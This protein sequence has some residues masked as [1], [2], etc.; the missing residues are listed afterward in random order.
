MHIITGNNSSIVSTEKEF[1]IV[2]GEHISKPLPLDPEII[3]LL[4]DLLSTDET[5]P[6]V[7]ARWA[8][9][10]QEKRERENEEKS[11]E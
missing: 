8:R 2:E 1:V 9:E 10:N 6:E 3:R 4:K 11:E 7:A 5:L